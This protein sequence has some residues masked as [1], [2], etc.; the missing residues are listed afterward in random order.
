MIV[1]VLVTVRRI[2]IRRFYSSKPVPT[3]DDDMDQKSDSS[4]TFME[5]IEVSTNGFISNINHFLRGDYEIDL[6][7]D[8]EN[9]STPTKK[10]R[11]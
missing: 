4:N 8:D 11:R 7:G 10:N 9:S 3:R 5:D 1:S 6:G 2:A